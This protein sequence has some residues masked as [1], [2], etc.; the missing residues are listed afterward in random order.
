MCSEEMK[1]E[2]EILE[3]L[4]NSRGFSIDLDPRTESKMRQAVFE[5]IDER[6][7]VAD[8][9][10]RPLWRPVLAV[11]LP[12][13]TGLA[14][15][16]SDYLIEAPLPTDP[17]QTVNLVT[18]IDAADELLEYFAAHVDAEVEVE[19]EVEDVE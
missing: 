5:R 16:Q 14:F 19:V 6:A 13:A 10:L 18:S 17:K 15:G 8:W 7:R 12:F 1:S 9:L 2:E 11:L 3:A 4:R